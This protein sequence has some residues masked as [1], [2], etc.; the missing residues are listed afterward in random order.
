MGAAYDL[1]QPSLRYTLPNQQTATP[2]REAKA[3][4]EIE[5]PND[6]R[7]HVPMGSRPTSEAK[8]TIWGHVLLFVKLY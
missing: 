6:D 7:V 1:S 2:Q 4:N 8:R 3:P 5:A